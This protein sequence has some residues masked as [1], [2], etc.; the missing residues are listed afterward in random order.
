MSSPGRKLFTTFMWI[1]AIPF[2]ALL[3]LLIF[4]SGVVHLF[5]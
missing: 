2:A 3:M 4:V 1:L 5:Q